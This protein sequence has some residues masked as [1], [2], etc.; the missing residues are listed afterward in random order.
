MDTT[1]FSSVREK[2]VYP[3]NDV[4]MTWQVAST[5]LKMCGGVLRIQCSL[6]WLFSSI[7]S[8]GMVAQRFAGHCSGRRGR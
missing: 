4:I 7:Y 5:Y 1:M 6:Q 3:E 2:T 8:E